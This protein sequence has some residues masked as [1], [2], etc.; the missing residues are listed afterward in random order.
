MNWML[1][2]NVCKANGDTDAATMLAQQSAC[3]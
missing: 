2:E 3:T 1:V